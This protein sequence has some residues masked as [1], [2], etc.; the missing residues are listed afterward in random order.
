MKIPKNIGM[1]RHVIELVENKQ[2]LYGFIYTFSQVELKTLKT[3]IKT[4]LKI[5]FIQLSKSPAD[6]FILFNKKL[7]NN[8][9]LCINYRDLKNLTIKN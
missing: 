8:F 4:H 7:G 9:S 6:T 5:Q 3:Y 1:N 2:P